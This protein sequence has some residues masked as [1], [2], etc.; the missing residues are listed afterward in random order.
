MRTNDR[1]M[2]E[3]SVAVQTTEN[4]YRV[5]V[6]LSSTPQAWGIALVRFHNAVP[7][8]DEVP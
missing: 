6:W 1:A 4:V 2:L 3:A 7:A 5:A 8:L